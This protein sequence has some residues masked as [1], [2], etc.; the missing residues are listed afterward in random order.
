MA[1]GSFA[2]L[3]WKRMVV[4]KTKCGWTGGRK[5]TARGSTTLNGAKPDTADARLRI[6]PRCS[7]AQDS[8]LSKSTL[9]KRVLH[10]IRLNLRPANSIVPLLPDQILQLHA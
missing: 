8:R 6:E 4:S 3:C 2:P 10:L 9:E 1:N 5:Y 7:N